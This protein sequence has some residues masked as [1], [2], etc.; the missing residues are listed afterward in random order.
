LETV[1][2]R[3][4]FKWDSLAADKVDPFGG[5]DLEMGS[6]RAACMKV[7]AKKIERP[8][9]KRFFAPVPRSISGARRAALGAVKRSGL[10]GAPHDRR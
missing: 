8:G 9:L 7:M 6:P 10:L 2:L 4:Y 1:A 5:Y 3:P